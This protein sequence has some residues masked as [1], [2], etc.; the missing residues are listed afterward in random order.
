MAALGATA[1]A[2]LSILA[3]LGTIDG[4]G[5][6]SAALNAP[7]TLTVAGPEALLA[8]LEEVAAERRWSFLG[9]DLDYA[10]HSAAMDGLRD[11][12]LADLAGLAGQP[13][14]VPLLSTVTGAP[15]DAAACG[16]A[17]WWRNLREPVQFQAAVQGAAALGPC[18]FL[19]IGPTPVLQ[20]YLRDTLRAVGSEAAI[21][22]SLSRRDPIADPFPGIADR[23]W[24]AGADP[25]GGPAFGG[26][27]RRRGLPHT[28][29]DRQPIWY[30]RTTEAGQA[31]APGEDP[32]LLAFR[33]GSE[34]G[35]W[36]RHI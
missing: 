36:S 19:E 17:H 30:G 13:P 5:I 8:R 27:A 24:M 33:Q 22:P 6:E 3:E 31:I 9:L 7:Q 16:P 18:L 26:P 29:F 15:L 14:R 32:P 34:P 25:R 1:E 28:P 12:L 11:G 23:A 2:A 20:G 35:L 4:R 21:L 10:F